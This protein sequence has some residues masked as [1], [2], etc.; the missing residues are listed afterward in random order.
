MST[1]AVPIPDEDLRFLRAWTAEQGTSAE[2][3]L[4]QQA[5]NL[6]EHVQRGLHP[7]VAAARGVILEDTP[8]GYMEHL[9][10]KH[11]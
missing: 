8:L 4:A 2:A 11:E 1:I 3:F 10:R 6:R 7:I 5:R 9:E